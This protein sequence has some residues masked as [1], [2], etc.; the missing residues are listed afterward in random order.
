MY[1]FIQKYKNRDLAEECKFNDHCFIMIRIFNRV[2]R[3][4]Y[5]LIILILY[6]ISFAILVLKSVKINTSRITAESAI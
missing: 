3:I 4:S 2:T 1:L 6:E 5:F